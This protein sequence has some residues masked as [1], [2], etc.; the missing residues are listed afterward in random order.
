MFKLRLTLNQYWSAYLLGLC[1]LAWSG[2]VLSAQAIQSNSCAQ[3][4]RNPTQLDQ[5]VQYHCQVKPRNTLSQ[6]FSRLQL[7]GEELQELLHADR[8]A[9][10]LETLKPGQQITLQVNKQTGQLDKFIL[11]LTLAERIEYQ[12]NIQ[13]SFEFERIQLAGDWHHDRLVGSIRSSFSASGYKAG[14][15]HSEVRQVVTLLEDKVDFARQIDR[16]DRFEVV[17]SKQTIDG[18][19][20]GKREL[21]MF[22]LYNRGEVYTAIRHSDGHFYD[23]DGRSLEREFLRYPLAEPYR[24]ITS[25]FNPHRKHPVSGKRV[26]HNGVDFACPV[27]TPVLSPADGTVKMI[28]KH[29][30]AGN[31]LV[32]DHLGLFQTRYLHLDKVLVQEG[33]TIRHG[34]EIGLAG[35][36][37][38]VTGAH[39]HFELLIDE[40]AQDPLTAEVPVARPVP[41]EE[42]DEFVARVNQLVQLMNQEERDDQEQ[43]ANLPRETASTSN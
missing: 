33:D 41:P 40:E 43:L 6:V 23:S 9:K 4:E 26:P 28:G 11:G 2:A 21:Q 36:T 35:K 13:G 10:V 3:P 32:I 31:Y 19:P 5:L 7:P 20:T 17:L 12:R 39:L 34:Q 29:P 8:N 1:Y 42:L 15:K 25:G 37:G 16:G 22:R 24:R 38:R 14:M 18:T 27:G 30:F